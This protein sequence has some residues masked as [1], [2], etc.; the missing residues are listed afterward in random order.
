LFLASENKGDH[1]IIDLKE[2][3]SLEKIMVECVTLDSSEV[4]KYPIDLIKMDIQG[5]EML[6][7]NG[8]TKI[9]KDNPKITIFAELWPYGIE[10]SGFSPKEFFD[11]L[12]SFGFE[13]LVI[14]DKKLIPINK[15]YQLL[16]EYQ[17]DD[18][19]NLFCRR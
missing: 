18:Y 7:L 14:K 16:T 5:A 6:A 10:K 8:M 11:K 15:D 3:D 19:V 13:I 1:R 9:L 17:F 2:D 4:S 12:E